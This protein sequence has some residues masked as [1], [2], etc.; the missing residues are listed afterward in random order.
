MPT[1]WWFMPRPTWMPAR[2]ASPHSSSRKV[3][4]VS[5]P[6]RSSTSSA[7]AAPTP[8]S[9]C[10]RTAKCRRKTCSAQ[11]DQGVE[12]LM[13][14]LDYER[15]VL[16]GGPLGHH[17]GRAWTS[18]LPYVHERKQFGQP[19]GEF[20]L[21][22]GKL[23]DMYVTMNACKSYVYAV[24]RACDDGEVTRKDA[25]GASFTPPRKRPGWRCERFS[26]W[27]AS[28][29]STITRPAACARCQAL[30]NRRGHFRDS[31]HG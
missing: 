6:R 15:A 5:P 22:Q 14:G 24:G 29:T 2:A 18:S 19:I 26:A 11:L 31:P 9:S 3:S 20:Q 1:C 17:A 16:A 23:A 28:A 30:R 21:M 27:A 4:K 7:C 10:S 13:S 25:A 12:V 8:A